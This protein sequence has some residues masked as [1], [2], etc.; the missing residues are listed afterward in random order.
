M[1]LPA[2]NHIGIM[3]SVRPYNTHD[4]NMVMPAHTHI[5]IM[6]IRRPDKLA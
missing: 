4:G 6:V 2:H 1:V 5:G 3:V